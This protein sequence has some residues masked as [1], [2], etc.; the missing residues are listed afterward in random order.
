MR[1][2]L[3]R[4]LDDHQQTGWVGVALVPNTSA[5]FW[6]IDSHGDPYNCEIQDCRDAFS[7][8]A[9]LD[10]DTLEYRDHELHLGT[11]EALFE[12]SDGW[13]APPWCIPS[14]EKSQ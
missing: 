2:Y 1:A 6:Q 12:T 3:F 9:Q 14:V 5:L 7:W 11:F 10:E 4:F 8:C 13:R